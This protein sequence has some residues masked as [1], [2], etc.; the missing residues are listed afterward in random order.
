MFY[1]TEA[2]LSSYEVPNEATLCTYI[3]GCLNQCIDCHYPELRLTNYGD[4]LCKNYSSL[5]Q[6]YQN[7]ATCICFLGEV[8]NGVFNIKNSIEKILIQHDGDL[9][10]E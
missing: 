5:L 4:P 9:E 6:L 2:G 8:A 10:I 7:Y 3:S 1:Y